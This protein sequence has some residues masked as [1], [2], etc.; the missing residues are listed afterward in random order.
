MSLPAS[1]GPIADYDSKPASKDALC[2]GLDASACGAKLAK[3][4]N[5][6]CQK[7]VFKCL[8][9]KCGVPCE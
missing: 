5:A 2:A 7:A 6:Y 1:E 9:E 4:Q 8:E 3:L